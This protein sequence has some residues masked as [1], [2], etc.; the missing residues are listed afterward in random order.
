M[1]LLKLILLFICLLGAVALYGDDD[2]EYIEPKTTSPFSQSKFV[3]DIAFIIDASANYRNIDNDVYRVMKVPGFIRNT[4]SQD[5]DVPLNGYQGLN[6]NSGELSLHADVDPYFELFCEIEIT[7]DSV[8][9]EE[10]FVNTTDLPGGFGLKIGKFLS[11]FG[12]L[13][14]QH[15]HNWNFVDQ[16]LVYRAFLSE[17][18]IDEVGLQAV[19]V[20]PSDI[21][22]QFGVEVLQGNNPAFGVNSF[23]DPTYRYH[24]K[25]NR[26]PNLYVG[27]LKSSFD[28]GDLAVLLGFSGAYGWTRQNNAITTMNLNNIDIE[29]VGTLGHGIKGK[30]WIASADLTFKYLIDS[31]RYIQF[32]SEFLFRRIL[33]NYF[34]YQSATSTLKTTLE[35]RQ[36]GLYSQ[37]VIK[38]FLRWR[39]GARFDLLNFNLVRIGG[40]NQNEPYNLYKISGMIDFSPSEFSL[41][42]LQYNYDRSGFNRYGQRRINHEVILQVNI[43]IGAHGAHSF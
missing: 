29:E 22:L 6:F 1:K 16:P 26:I 7:E 2:D 21:Y 40:I 12:R 13:N 28:I 31:Y 5:I 11:G 25:S 24:V 8:S 27:F 10:A 9:V 18:N 20:A 30:T 39:F 3:P 38:P 32:Q 33:G 43:S 14:G 4:L 37:L 19:W 42:R 34:L 36:S 35:K 17:S 15:G 23:H 41:F